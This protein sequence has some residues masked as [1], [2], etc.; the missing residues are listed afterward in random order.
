MRI[1]HLLLTVAAI[2]ALGISYVAVGTQDEDWADYAVSLGYVAVAVN[3][4][5][6]FG[7]PPSDLTGEELIR[8][9]T[10]DNPALLLPLKDHFLT[11]RREGQLTSV[12]LCEKDRSRAI[13]EDAGCTA[14]RLDARL[15][16]ESP[17]AACT[18][19]LDLKSACGGS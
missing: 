9:A 3:G 7:Q 2:A 13:A 1:R 4:Y 8:E 14:A 17:P 5:V 11:A 19:H 10:K 12:L 18:F 16:S 6:Q 15:W